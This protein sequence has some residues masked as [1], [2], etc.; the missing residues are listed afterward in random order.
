MPKKIY[1]KRTLD[2]RP[3]RLDLRDREYR[4][5]LL[6]LPNAWPLRKDYKKLFKTYSNDDMVL[7]QGEEGACTGFGLAAVINYLLWRDLFDAN[8]EKDK[9][10]DPSDAT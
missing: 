9:K 2:V 6:S 3:D 1:K 5:P 8:D 4:P 10:Y 7:D